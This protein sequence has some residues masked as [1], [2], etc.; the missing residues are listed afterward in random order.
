MYCIYLL[1][2]S[3]INGFLT[4]WLRP[5]A[6]TGHFNDAWKA[7]GVDE[8]SMRLVA[9]QTDPVFAYRFDWDEL[10]TALGG[11]ICDIAIFAFLRL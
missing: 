6:F 4:S 3:T 2:P 8:V 9:S 10:L 11:E 7:N 1:Q 5:Q